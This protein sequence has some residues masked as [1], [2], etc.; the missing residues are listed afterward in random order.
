MAGFRRGV[1]CSAGNLVLQLRGSHLRIWRDGG[2]GQGDPHPRAACEQ[3]ASRSGSRGESRDRKPSP[4]RWP[5]HSGHDGVPSSISSPYGS[6]ALVARPV[7]T[8]FGQPISPPTCTNLIA[9]Q[10]FWKN[11]NFLVELFHF[12]GPLNS[13]GL[14]YFK[15]PRLFAARKGDGRMNDTDHPVRHPRVHLP[16]RASARRRRGCARQEAQFERGVDTACH[17]S[18]EFVFFLNYD[19][20]I[21][22]ET[23]R[24]PRAARTEL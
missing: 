8:E 9:P 19:R 5:W 7:T 10:S 15:E 21:G 20:E 18:S 16:D 6:H 1:H 2:G 12:R 11:A 23:S 3:S 24:H 22:K 13:V 14:N 17:R 4:P